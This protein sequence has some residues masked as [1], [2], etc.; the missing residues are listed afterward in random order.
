MA[1]KI[2]GKGLGGISTRVTTDDPRVIK[3][4]VEVEC[5]SYGREC[6]RQGSSRT[7]WAGRKVVAEVEELIAE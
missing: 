6:Q 3:F 7:W 1:T 5:T 2:F 4:L